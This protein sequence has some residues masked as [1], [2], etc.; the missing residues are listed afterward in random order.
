MF[1][2]WRSNVAKRIWIIALDPFFSISELN[3]R[4]YSPSPSNYIESRPLRLHSRGF[5]SH[6]APKFKLRTDVSPVLP[7]FKVRCHDKLNHSFLKKMRPTPAL[8]SFFSNTNLQKK[9]LGFIGIRTRI[10]GVDVKHADHLTT[11]TALANSFL[12]D[13]IKTLF[14]KAIFILWF[15]VSFQNMLLIGK[16]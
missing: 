4:P 3:R 6:L 11:T 13:G 15:A 7:P 2:H 9:T 5:A 16:K 14:T 10:V 12:W 1:R 8:F